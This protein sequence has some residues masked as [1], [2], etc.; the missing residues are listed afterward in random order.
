M[1][2]QESTVIN[3]QES[4]NSTH[5]ISFLYRG[6]LDWAWPFT[7]CVPTLRAAL[8]ERMLPEKRRNLPVERENFLTLLAYSLSLT[9]IEK[10]R[11]LLSFSTLTDEQIYE[12]QEVFIDEIREFEDLWV[13]IRERETIAELWIKALKSWS[14]VVHFFS[15]KKTDIDA[16]FEALYQYKQEKDAKDRS[17]TNVK[18]VWEAIYENIAPAAHANFVNA[19]MRSLD[20]HLFSPVAMETSHFYW[21]N[22]AKVFLDDTNLDLSEAAMRCYEQVVVLNPDHHEA[23][24]RAAMLI[25]QKDRDA[26]KKYAYQ[27]EMAKKYLEY[28]LPG[29]LLDA[30]QQA[31]STSSRSAKLTGWYALNYIE[32]LFDAGSDETKA[33]DLYREF[34]APKLFDPDVPGMK[35]SD[36]RVLRWIIAL[37][38]AGYT[39]EALR[40]SEI[41]VEPSLNNTLFLFDWYSTLAT[42]AIC[43][44]EKERA[45]K[46]LHILEEYAKPVLDADNEDTLTLMP[47][48]VVLALALGNKDLTEIVDTYL[49][50]VRKKPEYKAVLPIRVVMATILMVAAR[51]NNRDDLNAWITLF[52]INGTAIDVTDCV[53]LLYSLSGFLKKKAAIFGFAALGLIENDTVV[54]SKTTRRRYGNFADGHSYAGHPDDILMFRKIFEVEPVPESNAPQISDDKENDF[55]GMVNRDIEPIDVRSWNEANELSPELQQ[56]IQGVDRWLSVAKENQQKDDV[57]P[58]KPRKRGRPRKID[59]T[60]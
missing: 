39:E 42:C 58:S 27:P 43:L 17:M 59:L 3:S 41:R 22:L 11:V 36:S 24:A 16:M 5:P 54:V 55:A 34:I 29:L 47:E 57:E 4:I 13:K 51:S 18:I 46:Y 15:G 33:L 20:G 50:K 7:P 37:F 53:E 48:L 32:I 12:L 40:I 49:K 38:R 44:G 30:A 14:I 25:Q 56:A 6:D 28:A 9:D 35:L 19:T 21:W 52:K 23:L 60:N 26:L 31:G 2:E 8:L 45:I 1:N 10:I